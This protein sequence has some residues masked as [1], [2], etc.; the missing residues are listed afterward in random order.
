VLFALRGRNACGPSEELEWCC[1]RKRRR[2]IAPDGVLVFHTALFAL[3]LGNGC[4]VSH[5]VLRVQ[6]FSQ[7][8]EVRVETHESGRALEE[9]LS[10][11]LAGQSV[12]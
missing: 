9:C 4:L 8:P 3:M 11:R 2:E 6:R 10:T 1:V 12:K 7:A 5:R